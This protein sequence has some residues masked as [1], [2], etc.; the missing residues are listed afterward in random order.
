MT[1]VG[2]SEHLALYVPIIDEVVTCLALDP[3][4][5]AVE[6]RHWDVNRMHQGRE[7]NSAIDAKGKNSS[8]P[9]LRRLFAKHR[10]SE[11]VDTLLFQ[12]SVTKLQVLHPLSKHP[13]NPERK[14][15]AEVKGC[16]VPVLPNVENLLMSVAIEPRLGFEPLYCIFIFAVLWHLSNTGRR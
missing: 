12:L 10:L 4:V 9:L 3:V 14:H 6:K 15:S 16:D 5:L 2:D 11:V 13:V 8:D 1:A 7:R